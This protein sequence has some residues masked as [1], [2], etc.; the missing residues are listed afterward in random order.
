VT[1]FTAVRRERG[2]VMRRVQAAAL[3]LPLIIV[4]V[5]PLLQGC[6]GTGRGL[7]IPDDPNLIRNEIR[8]IDNEIAQTEEMLKGARAELQI[9]D[10]T[11]IREQIREYEI[12]LIHLDSRKRA[13][14]ERLAELDKGGS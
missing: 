9:D 11:A 10:S 6:A 1:G 13:L 2:G 12:D 4:C 5:V 3:L 14:E 7:A 8:E